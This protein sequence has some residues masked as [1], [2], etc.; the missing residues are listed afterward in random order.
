MSNIKTIEGNLLDFPGGINCIAHSCNTLNIMG[1]GI[2]KQIKDRYP[3]AWRADC[4]AK[5]VGSNTL[6]KYSVGY[7]N[8]DE[9]IT[10]HKIYNMY[11]QSSIG[12][13]VRVDYDAFTRCFSELNR[14][15]SFHNPHTYKLGVP[16]K[17]SCGLAGGDWEKIKS[18]LENIFLDSEVE[19]TIVKYNEN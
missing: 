17:I 8:N 16:Y 18:I 7:I 15:I 5:E 14:H 3:I 12:G 10:T 11:T 6:G 13:G 4:M 19:L 9:G 2:A 1:G